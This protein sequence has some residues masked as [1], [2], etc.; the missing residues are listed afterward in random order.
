[1]E[2]SKDYSIVKKINELI[3]NTQRLEEV[4]YSNKLISKEFSIERNLEQT[5]SVIKKSI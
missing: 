5:L 4:K 3:S 2:N 1:M